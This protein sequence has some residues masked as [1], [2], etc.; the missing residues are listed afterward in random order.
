LSSGSSNLKALT[1]HH[2]LTGD[3]LI[4]I[5]EPDVTTTPMNI[6]NRWLRVTQAFQQIW[7]RW[8]KGYL[9]QLQ[10]RNRWEGEKGPRVNIGTVALMKEDILS[11]LQWKLAR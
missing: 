8:Q 11:S 9:A 1:P 3:S 6:S 4:A 10:Q 7:S 2:F 5:T